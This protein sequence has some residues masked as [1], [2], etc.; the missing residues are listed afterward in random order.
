MLTTY[1]HNGK[2]I[3]KAENGMLELLDCDMLFLSGMTEID[4]DGPNHLE[5][6]TVSQ[7]HNSFSEQLFNKGQHTNMF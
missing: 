4:A 3:A 5:I 2:A 7:L 1:L 6:K